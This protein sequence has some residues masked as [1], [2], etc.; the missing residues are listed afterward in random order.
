[1]RSFWAGFVETTSLA[2]RGLQNAIMTAS[3]SRGKGGMRSL[4]GS[5]MSSTRH[6][7]SPGSTSRTRASTMRSAKA[8]SRKQCHE[9]TLTLQS[10]PMHMINRT[11]TPHT[12][13]QRRD[14]CKG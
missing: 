12:C 10:N 3:A 11:A 9:M 2:V 4:P 1:V 7:S 5:S 13:R 14:R 8:G 6:T